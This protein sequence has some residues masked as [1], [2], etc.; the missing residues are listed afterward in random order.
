M[1]LPTNEGQF[2]MRHF[3]PLS[4][5][6]TLFSPAAG[7]QIRL[8][9]LPL[10]SRPLN[11]VDQTLNDAES[12]SLAAL[13][14]VRS[15]QI[16]R[17]VRANPKT[18]DVDDQGN[19]VVRNQVLALSPSASAL[20]IA[21]ALHF[22][23][24][25]E[26]TMEGMDIRIV[27]FESPTNLSTRKAVRQ[28]RAADPQGT[29]DFN[30]IYTGS[31]SVDAAAPPETNSRDPADTTTVA[32]SDEHVR[33][34]LVDSGVNIE[35]SVFKHATVR[36]WGCDG[37][38]VPDPHGTA[39][40][41]LIV[42]QTEQFHGVRPH[43]ELFAADIYCGQ[44]TGGALDAL[45]SAFDWLVRQ[46]VP[47]INVSLV[48]PANLMLERAVAALTAQGFVIVAAVGND[49]PAAPPLY[50]ASYPRVV[51][52]TGVDAHNKVLI[53]AA[54][55][56][57]VMFASPGADLAA[58]ASTG[59]FSAVRGTSFAAPIVAG[60][61]AGAV[62]APNP[63][64]AAAAIDAQAKA[65]IDLGAPGRDSTYGFGLL[66]AEYRIDPAILVHH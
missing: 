18:L 7:A 44:A 65:A 46:R 12:R 19:P 32:Q 20:R 35:H 56:P 57:Q 53:E 34:G 64:A 40:A 11:S 38:L 29:Y 10:V 63:T 42:G 24:L 50:P 47:V 27:V 17:L 2:V 60:L 37:H 66:G 41:S 23:V 48:G 26:Q 14:E 25:R 58:A 61:L 39:V 3:W 33:I 54:R 43:A 36:P 1:I 4:L 55:G 30:H 13:S 59:G 16:T 21:A 9:T 62:S 22:V 52:V 49:G 28:L 8:P 15:L 5:A 31:G 6:L 45:L 51:G